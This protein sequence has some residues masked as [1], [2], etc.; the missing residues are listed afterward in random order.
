M[1][2]SD[3]DDILDNVLVKRRTQT[4]NHELERKNIYN[5]SNH[6]LLSIKCL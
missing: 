3:M 6:H 4:T 1:D 5:R 2:M